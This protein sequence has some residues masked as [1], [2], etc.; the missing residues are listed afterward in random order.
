MDFTEIVK[1]EHQRANEMME[2]LAE[3][4]EGALKTRERLARQL[5]ELLRDHAQKEE[6]HLYPALERHREAH[7]GI[8]EF[9]AGA[10][11]AHAD[12]LQRA[13]AL[14]AM[15][16][17]DP[18]FAD[19]AGALRKEAQ[20][21]MRAEERL[22]GSL[23]KALDDA[24]ARALDEAMAGRAEEAAEPAAETAAAAPARRGAES[25][26]ANEP[27][28]AVVN[29][30]G[31]SARLTADD[32]QAIATCSSIAAGG[33]GELRQAWVEWLNRNLRAGA[34]A[35]QELMRCT[36][37]EQVA[38]I[39]RNFLKETL[40]NLLEG[41]AQMLRISSRVS[42]HA[43]RPIEDRVL[44]LRRGGERP[45]RARRAG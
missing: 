30:Y 26:L 12:M 29:L 14:D 23:R 19:A 20:Q 35:S 4:S 22:L 8:D 41:S 13:E 21:H 31:E 33:I 1:R 39:Q 32:M 27:A 37:L 36:K 7:D 40:D 5:A 6:A 28:L 25:E 44:Q 2:R 16:K 18:S 43:A 3:S 38:D 34:R 9:L 42:E 17:D 45:A 11:A 15:A 10:T 24:D